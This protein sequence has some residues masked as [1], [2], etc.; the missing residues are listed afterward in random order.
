MTT[1]T[2][3]D[4]FWS[5]VEKTDYCWLWT[6]SKVDGY[7]VF[8]LNGKLLGAHVVSHVWHIGFVP[9][10]LVVDHMCHVRHCVNPGHLRLI[11]RKQNG[12]NRTG[13]NAN[14]KSGLRGVSWAKDRNKWMASVR[15]QGKKLNLGYFTDKEEAGR[16]AQEAREKLFTPNPLSPEIGD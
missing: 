15:H 7:G 12:E 9:K 13:L 10:G 6:T 4:R 2:D 11:T 16:V 5:K 3:V 8:F 1:V 14:N